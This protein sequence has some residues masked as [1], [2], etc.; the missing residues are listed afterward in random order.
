M[1][2]IFATADFRCPTAPLAAGKNLHKV[3][4]Y[5]ALR[6]NDA[7]RMTEVFGSA[8]PIHDSSRWRLD[9][10]TS[11]FHH[12]LVHSP[13]MAH[14]IHSC[15]AAS[16]LS[17]PRRLTCIVV[18]APVRR[19]RRLSTPTADTVRVSR[20]LALSE[21]TCRRAD[22][23]KLAPQFR[24]LPTTCSSFDRSRASRSHLPRN[25]CP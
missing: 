20:F 14:G 22:F 19:R 5:F 15:T 2:G 7:K 17:L 24:R 12:P 10:I 9:T 8:V 1:R 3:R 6:S 18:R 4:K 25:Y 16:A 21:T 11:K 13:E 23:R